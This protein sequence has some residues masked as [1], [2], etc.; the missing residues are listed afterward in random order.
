MNDHAEKSKRKLFEVVLVL[1]LCMLFTFILQFSF[2]DLIGV[3]GYY[4]IAM[5]DLMRDQGL[6]L[7]GSSFPYLYLTTLKDNFADQHFLYHVLLIPF[8]YLGLLF[9]AKVAA[10]FFAGLAFFSV[11]LLLRVLTGK[12]A[13]WLILFFPLLSSGFL[14]RMFLPRAPA[15][16]LACMLLLI[17]LQLVY[18]TKKQSRGFLALLSIGSFFFVWLYGGFVLFG[19]W[20]VMYTAVSLLVSFFSKSYTSFKRVLKS[21]VAVF[22]G[23]IV[24]LLLHPFFPE[25]LQFLHIQIFKT[26]TMA[27]IPV[28]GEW[29][30]YD[31]NGF[32]S[33]NGIALL[34]FMLGLIALAINVVAACVIHKM[35]LD[36]EFTKSGTLY[37]FRLSGAGRSVIVSLGLFSFLLFIMTLVSKRYVEYFV[38]FAFVFF[39]A[40]FVYFIP[41]IKNG[42]KKGVSILPKK[43]RSILSKKSVW[44]G[45]V[46]VILLACGIFLYQYTSIYAFYTSAVENTNERP[47]SYMEE[48]T[49]YTLE[50]IPEGEIIFNVS[51]DDFPALFMGDRKHLY[52]WGLDPLF[53]YEHDPRLY[54]QGKLVWDVEDPDMLKEII[55]QDF[56]STYI[57]VNRRDE[58]L[59]QTL[60]SRREFKRLVGNEAGVL[61]E[62][63]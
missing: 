29:S 53:L 11:Y 7:N 49:Q 51:W 24:G 2:S 12:H 31:F 18:T 21:S 52:V 37:W 59:I 48:I 34:I 25:I 41:L 15:V 5:A 23:F 44:G 35:R 4:H 43:V 13:W 14:F 32:V 54:E 19:V 55:T 3:D 58:K 22:L 16:S 9:G 57:Y 42:I 20:C 40:Q 28:G 63:L 33:N 36:G 39:C 30:S 38:P 61:Y 50:H 47:Y 56:R 45:S 26:G 17:A 8:T 46:F 62:V 60:D 10:A 1:I 6:T 27:S